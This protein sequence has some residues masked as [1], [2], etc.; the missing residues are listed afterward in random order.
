[1]ANTKTVNGQEVPLTAQEE[2][3]I[4]AKEALWAQ[5]QSDNKKVEYINKRI[6]EYPSIQDQLNAL[7][8][9]MDK[10]EIPKANAFYNSIK[11]VNDKHPKPVL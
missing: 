3:E 8:D 6:T 4:V 1:M 7:W 10:G 11:A 5:Q 2:A 9:A